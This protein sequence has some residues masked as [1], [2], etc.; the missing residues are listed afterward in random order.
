MP[1]CFSPAPYLQIS[2]DASES[3]RLAA[4]VPDCTMT[5]SYTQLY[6]NF[7]LAS[8]QVSLDA[9]EKD[10]FAAA[11]SD[12]TSGK[13]VPEPLSASGGEEGGTET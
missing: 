12:C 11:V 5:L 1:A 10:G 3:D 4:A 7:F 9:S 6:I 8:M 13:V 2:L